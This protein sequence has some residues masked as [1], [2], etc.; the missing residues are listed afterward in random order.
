MKFHLEQKQSAASLARLDVVLI[1]VLCTKEGK[2]VRLGRF[3]EMLGAEDKKL[4]T[5]YLALRSRK[6]GEAKLIRLNA[7]PGFVLLATETL[8]SEQT[9]SLMIRRL[10]RTAKQEGFSVVGVHA[11]DYGATEVGQ[12]APAAFCG[13]VASNALYAHYDFSEQFKTPPKEGWRRVANV[14][15]Y[16]AASAA[17][18]KAMIAHGEVIAEGVNQCRSIANMPPSDL[19][20]EGMAEAARTVA[21]DVA[22]VTVTVFDEKKLRQEGMNAILA[23]GQGSASPPRL[24]IME[25][26]GGKKGARPLA[27]VGKGVTFDSGGLNLKPGESMADMHM[28]MSGGAAVIFALRTIAKL[29]L[30]INVVG[31]VPAVENMVSG[32]SYRQGDIIR[33]YGGKT[34]EV[35][36]TDAEGRVILADAIAYAL[37]KKPVLIVEIST[38][39]G[40]AEVALGQRVAALF[41]KNNKPLQDA[42]QDI[43]AASGDMVWPMPLWDIHEKDVESSVADLVNLHRTGSRWGGAITGA[44]FLSSIAGDAAFAHIDMAPRMVTLPEEE[45][46]SRGA[47][48]FGVRF[49]TTLAARW[50]EVQLLVK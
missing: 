35:A 43:G 32:F 16:T 23:V 38:L 29:K 33:S 8:F 6:A 39:T 15:I 40:A 46:L 13:L 1:P 12:I 34:I 42:L 25:Y 22:G 36:N 9:I 2:P 3:F 31:V 27:L 17:D 41:V 18:C 50:E 7:A 28:D 20:P 48:G 45:Y 21:R 19:K 26:A 37:T 44:A 30:P 4:I 47:A 14:V 10:I 11:D 49:F 5:N 24:I